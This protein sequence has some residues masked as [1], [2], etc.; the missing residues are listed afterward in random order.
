MSKI[1]LPQGY[2]RCANRENNKIVYYNAEAG[3]EQ[4]SHPLIDII[5]VTFYQIISD[6]TSIASFNAKSGKLLNFVE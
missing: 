2:Q 1:K 6:S 4:P 5:K 3:L